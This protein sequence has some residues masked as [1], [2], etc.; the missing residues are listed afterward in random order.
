MRKSR[1][2]ERSHP[3][4]IQKFVYNKNVSLVTITRYMYVHAYWGINTQSVIKVV[5][6]LHKSQHKHQ[7]S[8]T[9]PTCLPRRTLTAEVRIQSQA[10]LCEIC[11]SWSCTGTLRT[12]STSL[13]PPSASFH[14]HISTPHSFMHLSSKLYRA[15]TR[16]PHCFQ[17]SSEKKNIQNL[18]NDLIFI[19]F[20]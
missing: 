8:S 12:P 7:H 14:Q 18:V 11:G 4:L 1:E 16:K 10:S 19:Y 9:N 5:I 2:G 15:H 17:Q 6:I 3:S 20:L 13:F